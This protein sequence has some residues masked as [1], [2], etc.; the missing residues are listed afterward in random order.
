MSLSQLAAQLEQAIN[1]RPRVSPQLAMKLE[2]L[3]LAAGDKAPGLG[4]G[5]SLWQVACLGNAH[6]R[7]NGNDYIF[8]ADV[9]PRIASDILS[10]LANG[11]VIHSIHYDSGSELAHETYYQ[12]NEARNGAPNLE[13]V[14]TAFDPNIMR[15]YQK[16]RREE[17][18]K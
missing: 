11:A 15:D 10:M 9:P 12:A 13:V 4:L 1:A 6:L 5:G 3:A 8:T 14:F 16:A 2:N 18:Y 7:S 17:C